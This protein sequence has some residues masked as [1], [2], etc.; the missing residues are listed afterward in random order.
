MKVWSC[1]YRHELKKVFADKQVVRSMFLLPILLVFVTSLLTSTLDNAASDLQIPI[2]YVLSNSEHIQELEEIGE[3]IPTEATTLKELESNRKLQPEAVVLEFHEYETTI[4]YNGANA[5]SLSIMQT[6]QMQLIQHT[7][8]SFADANAVDIS[9]RISVTNV[10]TSITMEMNIIR[11][12]LPYMLVLSLFQDTSSFAID[13]IAGEKERG[14]FSKTILAPISPVPIIAGKV[15]AG[16]ICGL[17][18]SGIYMLVMV[19]A[20]FIPRL[21][22][23]GL[24]KAG[25]TPLMFVIICLCAAFLSVLFAGLSVLCSLFAKTEAEANSMRTP[26]FGIIIVLA[27]AA[28][29]RTGT[30]SCIHYMIPVYNIC[31]IM[32]DILNTTV[33]IQNFMWM[34]LSLFVCC[35]I[36]FVV[37]LSSVNKESVRY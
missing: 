31:I 33:E 26:V 8:Q 21:D 36:L 37:M 32:Q 27:L 25:I 19:S 24:Q 12:L 30:V 14:I 1:I 15:A 17:L 34:L 4:Y 35:A 28:L 23:F 3:V 5:T 6:C 16:T 9:D 18:N 10:A 29:L 22:V 11:M 20:S 7:L 2:I 13:A